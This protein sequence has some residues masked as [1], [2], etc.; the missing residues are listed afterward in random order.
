MVFVVIL[1][2]LVGSALFAPRSN[3][4]VQ[5]SATVTSSAPNR[6]GHGRRDVPVRI[7]VD[8]V[9]PYTRDQYPAVIR[10]FGVLVPSINAERQKSAEIAATY[11]QCDYVSNV[12]ITNHSTKKIRRYFVDCGNG[13]R[14]FIDKSAISKGDAFDIQTKDEY[15]ASGLNHQDW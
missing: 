7:E 10:Q 4:A 5:K 1:F 6:S 11:L 8:A 3:K 9:D 12:Q 2:A 15:L 14:V 13:A